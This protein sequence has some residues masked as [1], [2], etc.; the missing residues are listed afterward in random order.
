MGTASEN[1]VVVY[2]NY[3][4]VKALQLPSEII[5]GILLVH[6]SIFI[7]IMAVQFTSYHIYI[8]TLYSSTATMHTPSFV[9]SMVL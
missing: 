1:N 4:Q 8:Y 5:L 6:I 7:C 9:P 2:N 3:V